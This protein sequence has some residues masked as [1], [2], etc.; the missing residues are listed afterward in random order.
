MPERPGAPGWAALP[1]AA[2][3]A[4]AALAALLASALLGLN[5]PAANPHAALFALA[6]AGYKFWEDLAI[7]VAHQVNHER[8]G[9]PWTVRYE[10][11]LAASVGDVQEVVVREAAAQDIRPWQFWRTLP[12]QLF[13][14]ES[15]IVIRSLDD[16]GRAVLLGQ[17]FRSL[18]GVA[19]YLLVWLGALASL[20]VLCWTAWEFFEARRPIAGTTFLLL[21]GASPFF[22]QVLALAYS[23]AGFYLLGLL[24]LVPLLTY[25]V[26]GTGRS[27]AGFFLR[28]LAAGCLFA[29]YA[30]CRSAV[31]LLLPGF[32]F[33]LALA[34][35]RVFATNPTA[36]RRVWLVPC[37]LASV[38]LLLPY[39]A[40]RQPQ[41]HEVWLSLWEGLGDFDRTKGH[42][43]SDAAAKKALLRAGGGERLRTPQNEEV[44]RR[45]TLHDIQGDPLW[46]LEI[47]AERLFATVTQRKLW[48]WGPTAGISVEPA[49]RP[50][51][52]A[53]DAYYALTTPADWFGVGAWRAEAPVFVILLPTG[54]LLLGGIGLRLRGHSSRGAGRL[55]ETLLVLAG[56]AG[57][58]L[59]A[60]VVTTTAAAVEAQ[61]FVLVYLLGAGF[62]AEEMLRALH[63]RRVAGAPNA[64]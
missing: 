30:I 53:T 44:F 24:L 16:R 21:L 64:S 63:G 9:E 59:L 46:Y 37:A 38:L 40:I 14:R 34:A 57:A 47:L 41:R 51:E 15:T 4:G 28:V 3:Y 55:P 60:P 27:P 26:S 19:P 1:R 49:S 33:A 50:G 29:A 22:A 6:P 23:S 18:G 58:G 17:G 12:T 61:A 20:P 7:A 39:A 54:L 56:V 10:D 11:A 48:P 42:A 32:L 62:F 52:G 45:M 31:V 2:R 13:P 36:A 35:R 8:P 5:S 25:A 43:W